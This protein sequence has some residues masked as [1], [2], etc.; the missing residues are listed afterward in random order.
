MLRSLSIAILV[1]AGVLVLCMLALRLVAAG[2]YA[3]SG[4]RRRDTCEQVLSW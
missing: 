3:L 2:L 1:L 4:I